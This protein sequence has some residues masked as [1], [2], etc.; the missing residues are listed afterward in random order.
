MVKNDLLTKCQLS[1]EPCRLVYDAE[2]RLCVT[3]KSKLERVEMGQ[4]GVNIRFVAYQ[5]EEAMKALGHDYRPGR[6]ETAFLIRPSGEVQQGFE[7]FLP[8]LSCLR[9]GKVLLWA[10]RLPF[11]R[12]LAERGYR[13]IARHRYRWFGEAKPVRKRPRL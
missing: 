5:S 8:V 13:I 10:L 4:A 9:V 7:A 6:P 2:C 3:I 1:Q 12:Q 11:V